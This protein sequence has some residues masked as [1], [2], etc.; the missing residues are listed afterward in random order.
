[1]KFKKL[2]SLLC[3]LGV[4]HIAMAQK[5]AGKPK[6][7][8]AVVN[9]IRKCHLPSD[10]AITL[11]MTLDQVRA[12][13]DS[14][15]LKVICNDLKKYKLFSFDFTVITMSPFQT[16]EFG[17]GNGGIPILARKAIEKLN[18]KDGIIL[19]NATYKDDKG[20]EQK[21]PMITFSI[22]ELPK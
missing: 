1:M 11:K 21:L 22:A 16:L 2:F 10:S 7:A 20:I 12:W 9:P 18:P 17:T 6:K 19:K 13:A 14:L 15:P 3:L 5:P 4:F 8:K